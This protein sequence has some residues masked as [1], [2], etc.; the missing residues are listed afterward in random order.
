MSQ[1][2]TAI[3]SAESGSTVNLRKTPG[4]A[5]A[6]RLPVGSTVTVIGRQEGWVQVSQGGKTGWVM[7]QYIRQ[8]GEDTPADDA[9]AVGITLPRSLAEALRDALDASLGRG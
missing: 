6:D 2:Q 9:D 7:A 8:D 5:L 1:T 4:G 3:F